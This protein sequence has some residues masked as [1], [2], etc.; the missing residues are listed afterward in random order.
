MKRCSACCED[1]NINPLHLVMPHLM[2]TDG[3][4]FMEARGIDIAAVGDLRAGAVLMDNGE[5]KIQHQCEQLQH[6]GRC[7]IYSTRPKICRDFDCSTKRECTNLNGA[8]LPHGAIPLAPVPLDSTA[9]GSP[10]DD[11]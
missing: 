5:V 9:S 4:E 3:Q 8:A 1:F 2:G 11:E 10:E 7:G 6:D